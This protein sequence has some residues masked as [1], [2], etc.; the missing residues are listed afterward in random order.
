MRIKGTV[1]HAPIES[2]HTGNIEARIKNNLHALQRRI[3]QA[4][5]R[6]DR[7]PED[8]RI[9]AVT[10]NVGIEEVHILAGLGLNNFGENRVEAAR[11]K[12]PL[13]KAQI[14]KYATWHMIGNIQR[15]KVTEV[16]RL[17]DSLDALD[18]I[19]LAEAIQRACDKTETT[20]HALVEVNVSGEDVKHG[21][22]PEALPKALSE[23]TQ[24]DRIHVQG[25]MTMA[26]HH[27]DE[28]SLRENFRRLNDLAKEHE[29]T[30]ISMGMSDDFEIAIEEGATEIRIG[31]ALYR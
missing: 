6:S 8:V 26:P 16:V 28:A 23:L 14:E 29:L 17:F 2:P 30:D 24:F 11:D 21:F 22:S 7:S 19:S 3:A 1:M 31:R 20:L 27:A 18:R 10:K 15:R 13:A 25:L 12:I 4:A 5:E 9:V